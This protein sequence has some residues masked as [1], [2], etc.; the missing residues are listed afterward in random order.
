MTL[1][2]SA[3]AEVPH[4]KLEDAASLVLLLANDS[5]P[6]LPRAVDRLHA[7]IVADVRL[8]AAESELLRAGLR[9]L[10][11]PARHVAALTVAQLAALHGLG[12]VARALNGS[13]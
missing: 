2:L 12:G 10:D 13:G 9:A 5:D 1:A 3:A 4:V 11:S 7:R 8:T 6:R